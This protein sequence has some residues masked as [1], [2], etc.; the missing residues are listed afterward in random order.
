MYRDGNNNVANC[1][2]NQS[3]WQ[4]ILT[5]ENYIIKKHFEDWQVCIERILYIREF[6]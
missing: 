1:K 5:S 4:I 2:D 3:K 6:T